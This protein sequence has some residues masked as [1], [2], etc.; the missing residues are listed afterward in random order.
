MHTKNF[1]FSADSLRFWLSHWFVKTRLHMFGCL[2]IFD[3]MY[4]LQVVALAN[5]ELM[6]IALLQLMQNSSLH[7]GGPNNAEGLV[8]MYTLD[9]C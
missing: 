8:V 7:S 1:L 4:V 6:F 3:Y 5:V 2:V 9:I